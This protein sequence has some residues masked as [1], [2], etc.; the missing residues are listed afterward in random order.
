V[1]AV[2]GKGLCFARKMREPTH[3]GLRS[4]EQNRTDAF[5]QLSQHRRIAVYFNLGRA[6]WLVL[7]RGIKQLVQ[8]C[9][10]PIPSVAG[11]HR[12]V[13]A[14][15]PSC[16]SRIAVPARTQLVVPA[17]IARHRS[18]T[19]CQSSSRPHVGPS[20]PNEATASAPRR[21]VLLS[22][23]ALIAQLL[24]PQRS[25]A[26]EWVGLDV[27]RKVLRPVGEPE[28][29]AIVALLDARS[30]LKELAA[31]AATPLDSEQRF[32]SRYLLPGYA[33]YL[34]EVA[35]SAPVI[36][37]ALSGD[38]EATLS[39]KYGGKG[40]DSGLTDP[41]YEAIGRVLTISG[42]TIKK[43]AQVDPALA[44]QANDAISTFLSYVPADKVDAAQEFRI[45]R[46]KRA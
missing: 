15:M 30:T 21:V 23:A 39:E 41:V 13:G 14:K 36:E 10:C 46:A 26:M 18:Q 12:L 24:G 32:R 8:Y 7:E 16:S 38:V 2:T 40:L 9:T 5:S 43:E 33:K 28:Q 19:V 29:A 34:R 31:L 4:T 35:T 20:V 27:A 3:L 25:S 11:A 37:E 42:R 1:R 45:Q 22:G 6:M 17:N 44:Q